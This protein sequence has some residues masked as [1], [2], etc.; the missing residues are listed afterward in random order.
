MLT[1]EGCQR[2]QERMLS[3]LSALEADVFVT[4]DP[5]TAYYFSGSFAVEGSPTIFALWHD[6]TSLLVTPAADEALASD[7]R[8]V[9]TYSIQRSI[10]YPLQDALR[11]FA[12]ALARKPVPSAAVER[13]S[14]PGII[15]QQLQGAAIV[16]ATMP[17]LRLRKRKEPDEIEEI[18]R[19]LRLCAIAYDAAREAIAPGR[20]EIDV[21]NAMHAAVTREAGTVVPLPGDFACGERCISG[22]GPPTARQV[23]PGDLYILDIFPAPNYYAGDTCRA[24]AVGTPSDLQQRAWERVR[25]AVELAEGLIRPGV[26]ARNVYFAVKEYLD[27]SFWHHVGHGIGFRGHELPRIIPGTDEIFEAGD[28]I[29]VEPGMYSEALQGGIRLE[30]NYVVREGGLEN[31]FHYSRAL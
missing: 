19:S 3:Q 10:D 15:E 14:A 20:T 17:V 13:A 31:L 26:P 2:R 21:Y 1:R 28:V 7:V 5:R 27:E 23:R 8:R 12:D 16:D 6:G 11:L 4:A 22:G 18:R 29:A 24:F 25:G 9:E 30:D